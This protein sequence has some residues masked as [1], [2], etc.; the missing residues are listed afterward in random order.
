MYIYDIYDWKELVYWDS[1][2]A[3]GKDAHKIR[4]VP[5]P[6]GQRS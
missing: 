4:K 6:H 1:L 5:L 3:D 2:G